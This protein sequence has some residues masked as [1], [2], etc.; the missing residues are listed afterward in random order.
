MNTAPA[1]HKL[2]PSDLKKTISFHVSNLDAADAVFLNSIISTF[3]DPN[4]NL[5]ADAVRSGHAFM[6]YGKNGKM[7]VLHRLDALSRN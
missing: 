6:A 1:T 2:T 4:Q 7:I 5:Q 3:C